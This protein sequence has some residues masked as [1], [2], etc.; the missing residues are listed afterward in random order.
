MTGKRKRIIVDVP[1]ENHH[2]IKVKAARLGK[3]ISDVVRELLWRWLGR[4][5]GEREDEEPED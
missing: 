1:E 5:E 4:P 3:T 2:A